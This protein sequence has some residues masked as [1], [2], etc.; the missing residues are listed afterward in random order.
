MN[1]PNNKKSIQELSLQEMKQELQFLTGKLQMILFY[2][3]TIQST[4]KP[5]IQEEKNGIKN[6]NYEFVKLNVNM[7][8]KNK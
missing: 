5:E 4:Q 3:K 1:L 7:G 6:T 8:L 2:G